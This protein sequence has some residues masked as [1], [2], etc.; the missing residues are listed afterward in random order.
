MVL[1][2]LQ[3]VREGASIVLRAAVRNV[4]YEVL[5]FPVGA[6]LY[7]IVE[8]MRFPPKILP[9]MCVH[10]ILSLML[11]V[12]EGAPNCLEVEEIEICVLVKF[13]E[14]VYLKL[15]RLV[16]EGAHSLKFAFF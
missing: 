4:L 2:F 6:L 15:F 10:T 3:T 14:L 5:A 7:L 8:F 9:I 11:T 1:N 16:S 12:R 13:V